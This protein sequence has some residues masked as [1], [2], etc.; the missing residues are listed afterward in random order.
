MAKIGFCF[1]ASP[2]RDMP[3]DLT[4]LLGKRITGVVSWRGWSLSAFQWHGH[5]WRPR[6][7]L[8]LL[9]D[10]C[11]EWHLW[12]KLKLFSNY[13]YSLRVIIAVPTRSW[14]LSL[15]NCG[16]DNLWG[17]KCPWHRVV[18]Q[19]YRDGN[20]VGSFS[21]EKRLFWAWGSRLYSAKV[22]SLANRSSQAE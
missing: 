22:C 2:L 17:A 12:V 3:R 10:W 9:T 16:D 19:D 11:V 6:Q 20:F 7:P 15:E 4:D 21:A 14:K 13:I 5:V 18:R 1:P 8:G